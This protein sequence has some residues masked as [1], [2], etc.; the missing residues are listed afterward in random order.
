[1]RWKKAIITIVV[2]IIIVGAVRILIEVYDKHTTPSQNNTTACNYNDTNKSYIHKEK[3]CAINFLC[4][5]GK[6]PFSDECGCG[7][8]P[9]QNAST[10]EPVQNKC[11]PTQREA[12]VC[13]QLYQP[14][15]GWFNQSVQ[16]VTYPCA[17]TYTNDC[18]ACQDQHVAYWT[19]GACPAS[20]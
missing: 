3:N 5:K 19:L 4:I 11:T 17:K 12:E 7:C 1:M 6:V 10:S 2:L 9:A 16:C 18:Y 8:E 15:C 20:Q 13:Y 14:V